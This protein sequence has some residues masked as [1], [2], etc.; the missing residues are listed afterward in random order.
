[1]LNHVKSNTDKEKEKQWLAATI[2]AAMSK[3]ITISLPSRK[4]GWDWT[5]TGEKEI[6]MGFSGIN[7]VGK[8][9]YDELMRLI[10]QSGDR[11]DT[12]KPQLFFDL[13][14]SVFN[15]RAFE[16]CVKAGMFD[17]WSESREYLFSLKTKKKKKQLPGQMALFDL[18]SNE[19]EYVMKDS[20]FEKTTYKQKQKE[21]IEVCNFDLEKIK[22]FSNIKLELQ[23]RTGKE[24]QSILNFS[25][26][27]YYFFYLE[28]VQ[29]MVSK[30]GNPYL[31]L[32]VGDGI[33]TQ[34]LRAFPPRGNIENSVYGKIKESPESGVYISEF[35]KNQ[36]GFINFKNNAKFKRI[37]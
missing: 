15:K 37:K 13:P 32:K 20:D 6:S 9:A 26:D 7:G 36:K 31:T 25:E 19:F 4:S 22:E 5:M 16:A 11:L 23:K 28:T 18:R 3:G 33:S 10:N 8:K 27:G 24:I 17:D 34:T 35:V 29:E 12:I 1:L 14:F 30:N 21:F 2:A